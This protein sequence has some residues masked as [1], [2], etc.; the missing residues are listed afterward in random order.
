VSQEALPDFKRLVTQRTRWAQ[1]NIQCVK[2]IKE[3]LRSPHFDAGGVIEI[4]YYLVLPFL[5]VLGAASVIAL[6]GTRLALGAIDPASLIGDPLATGALLALTFT[7]SIV[8]FA[9]WGP[10]YRKRCEPTASF[11]QGVLWGLGSWIY[12]YYMYIC[13][14]GAFWR[15]IRGKS[16]WAKTRRNAETHSVGA[17]ALEA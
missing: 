17:V 11:R 15:V 8:P 7:F 3:I 12:V 13:I 2:Y 16:G 5:Q 1:G 9:M 14:F 4:C 6:F 10:I